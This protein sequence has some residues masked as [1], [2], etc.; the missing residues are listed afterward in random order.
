MSRGGCIT[1]AHRELA[2]RDVF[3]MGKLS[4]DRPCEGG[5]KRANW[6]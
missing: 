5:T 2:G 6:R 1:F 3:N 4:A